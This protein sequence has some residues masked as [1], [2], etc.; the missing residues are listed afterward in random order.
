MECLMHYCILK[1]KI[2]KQQSKS[3]AALRAFINQINNYCVLLVPL[4]DPPVHTYTQKVRPFDRLSA[5]QLRGKCL[6]RQSQPLPHER[7]RKLCC[8]ITK[9]KLYLTFL[10]TSWSKS[11]SESMAIHKHLER[12]VHSNASSLVSLQGPDFFP[13]LL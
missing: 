8:C 1:K 2:D 11:F 7:E 13:Y 4:M 5:S 6:S 3:K 12:K 9:E 10:G